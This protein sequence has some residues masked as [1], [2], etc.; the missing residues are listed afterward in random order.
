M[1]IELELGRATNMLGPISRDIKDRLR[2]YFTEPSRQ[3]WEMVSCTI[4]GGHMT[5]WQAWCAT[6]STAPRSGLDHFPD[7]IEF[8]RA[9]AHATRRKHAPV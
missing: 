1:S 2:D 3:K 7:R 9:L 6:E 5:V 8:H 4:V